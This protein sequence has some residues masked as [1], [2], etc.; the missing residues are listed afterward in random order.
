M[1]MNGLWLPL[2]YLVQWTFS[3]KESNLNEDKHKTD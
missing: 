3:D 2:I 1:A